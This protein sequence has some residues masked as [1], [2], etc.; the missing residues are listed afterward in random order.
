M[1]LLQ[2]KKVLKRRKYNVIVCYEGGINV[3]VKAKNENEASKKALMEVG[4][5]PENEF[6]WALEPQVCEIDVELAKD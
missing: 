1:K 4:V 2:S 6:L 5:I 3:C